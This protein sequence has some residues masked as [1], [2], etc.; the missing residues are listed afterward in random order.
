MSKREERHT[1]WWI[2]NY[3]RPTDIKKKAATK[4]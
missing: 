3:P 2:N 1:Q 4:V